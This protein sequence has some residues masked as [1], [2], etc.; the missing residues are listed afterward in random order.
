[1]DV[2]N[3]VYAQLAELYRS[4]TPGSR[5]TAGLLATVVL[6]SA[7]YLATHQGAS[8]EVDLMHGVSVA[9]GQL[10]VMEA[11]FAKA[12]LKGHEFRGTSIFVPRGQE[13][14]YM[15]ALVAGNAL[16]PS[17]GAAQHEAANGGS[18]FDFGPH[19]DQR[20]IIA[21]QEELAHSIR[22]MPGI[23]SANVLYDIDNRPGPFKDKVITATAMVKPAG[24]KSTRRGAGLGD[25]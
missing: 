3:R 17:P 24:R 14:D 20:M 13:A 16:P 6:L 7:G 1:M 5:L 21:K 2:L 12:N 18:M 9:A 15:A 11:A 23:E 25:P 10:P 22:Q 19:R 4:M 8:P